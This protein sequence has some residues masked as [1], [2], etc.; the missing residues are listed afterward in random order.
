MQL[1]PAK[2]DSAKLRIG[3]F[4]VSGTGKTF[5]A[6]KL[7]QGLVDDMS[8]VAVIDT[9]FGSASLYHDSFPGYL[10]L[11]M[12]PATGG[13]GF[14]PE[15]YIHCIKT[16]EDAGMEVIIIDSISHEWE[17]AG[18]CLDIQNKL[19]GKYQDWREVTPRHQK[20]I[21]TMLA[22]PAHIIACGRMKHDYSMERNAAGKMVVERI[23]TKIV[24]REGLDY[25]LTIAFSLD[26]RHMA[27]V[28]KDR[29]NMFDGLPLI[30]LSEKT[31]EVLRLW[32]NG[33]K[34]D[35]LKAMYL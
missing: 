23:G 5:S 7:A 4:G 19:G 35:V 33:E 32:S 25:E 20:F 3:L 17:G 8:K 1:K 6:L 34:A 29:T 14:S 28:E 2:R 10:T 24:T 18:G 11:D 21:D 16:C 22:C 31:G 27:T 13:D 30:K 12:D 15:K 9:E 26:H